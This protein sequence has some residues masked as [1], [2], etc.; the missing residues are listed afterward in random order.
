MVVSRMVVSRMAVSRMAV[1]STVVRSA[2]VRSAVVGRA[3]IGRAGRRTS[4]EDRAVEHRSLLSR[5]GCAVSLV[6]HADV[7]VHLT[8]RLIEIDALIEIDVLVEN[9]ARGR[10]AASG[11]RRVVDD[12]VHGI[13]HRA[14]A[15]SPARHATVCAT[16]YNAA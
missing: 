13:T 12:G 2:V 8:D 5:I 11:H 1:R 15:A 6:G 4:V 10:A 16:K 3:V 14:H 7:L 9:R